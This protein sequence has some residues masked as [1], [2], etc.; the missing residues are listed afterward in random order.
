MEVS[1]FTFQVNP[2]GETNVA[3]GDDDSIVYGSAHGNTVVFSVVEYCNVTSMQKSQDGPKG[4]ALY[5]GHQMMVNGF[6]N[7]VT[8]D[9][10]E[11]HQI[12]ACPT[13]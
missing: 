2:T 8:S 9:M 13:R 3:T 7:I 11:P 4:D 12:T 10:M 5:S 6:L 1:Y